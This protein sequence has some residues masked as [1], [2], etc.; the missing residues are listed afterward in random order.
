MANCIVFLFCCITLDPRW[1][2]LKSISSKCLL[3]L[4]QGETGG[5]RHS[6]SHVNS[7]SVFPGAI[8][9]MLFFSLLSLDGSTSKRDM[10]YRNIDAFPML[11]HPWHFPKVDSLSRLA[12]VAKTQ[13]LC[14]FGHLWKVY[15]ITHAKQI[16]VPTQERQQI[17]YLL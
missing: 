14:S 13:F 7:K 5:H 9:M 17:F 16:I 8:L 12:D 11:L 4:N 10:R 3:A 2:F 6:K 1:V 15:S